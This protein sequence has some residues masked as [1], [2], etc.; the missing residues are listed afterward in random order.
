MWF[1]AASL[2][3]VLSSVAHSAPLTEVRAVQLAQ[4]TSQLTIQDEVFK[5]VERSLLILP[6]KSGD[7]YGLAVLIDARGYFLAHSSALTSDSVR[8]RTTDGIEFPL[9][10]RA[11]DPETDLVLLV[12]DTYREVARKPIAVATTE[13]PRTE[14]TVITSK[15]V[16]KAF[17]SNRDTVGQ[18][19]N[20]RYVPLNEVQ[21]EASSAPVGG[22]LV[23]T[24]SGE[25]MG[26]VG[27]LLQTKGGEMNMLSR[28]L[29]NS[30]GP[31]GQTISYTLGQ[32]VIQRVVNGFK[33][34]G[35][36][37]KHPTIG[38]FFK[39]SDAGVVVDRVT[40]GGPS[41]L[42]GLRP[43]DLVREADGKAIKSPTELAVVLFD[44]NPGDELVLKVQRG[45]ET[46]D[47][48]VRVGVASEVKTLT[49]WICG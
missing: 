2:A 13:T 20:N 27:A 21:M 29:D 48:K 17:L 15:G 1:S 30:Y 24:R 35:H 7:A 10:K 47:A 43:G 26:V 31:Q 46:F 40:E 33:S 22:A 36:Q 28:Q 19:T 8:A 14:V 42:A 11:V 44:Q 37:V 12:S 9:V 5:T 49:V 25:L 34:E 3:I 39:G 6:D 16:S 45:S 4:S 18:T 38:L 41:A 23:F 32:A